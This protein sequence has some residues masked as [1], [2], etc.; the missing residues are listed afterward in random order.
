VESTQAIST[1]VRRSGRLSQ[2]IP[3]ILSGGDADGR[4]FSERT[5][6]LVLS[7]H[8]ATILSQHKVI[9]EQEI[10]LRVVST[11][12]EIEV[13]ICGEIGQREDG[14]IYG[15]AFADPSI[16]FWGIEFPPP[17]R[18]SK[19]I[20]PLTLECS[21]CHRQITVN[22]DG[23]EIDVYTVNEGTLRYCGQCNVSTMWKIAAPRAVLADAPVATMPES[24]EAKPADTKSDFLSSESAPAAIEAPARPQPN[25]RGERRM[26][27]NCNACIRTVGSSDEIVPCA[28]MSRG[29]FSFHSSRQYSEETMIEAAVPYT[30][31]TSIFVPAQIANVRE[32]QKGKLFRYGVAYLRGSK[33]S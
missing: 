2:H 27:A 26:K 18:F 13:R 15:V 23:T 4:Q 8:G 32:L 21:G 22:F 5:T 10:Y 6:T 25:R 29:G 24:N 12:R 33:K 7:R 14:H 1:N 31:S 3:I 19:D 28:D 30:P 16:D 11:N 20:I 9:P 17:E